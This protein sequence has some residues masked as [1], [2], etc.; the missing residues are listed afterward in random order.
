MRTLARTPERSSPVQRGR[1]SVGAVARYSG[2]DVISS[3]SSSWISFA[4]ATTR[5]SQGCGSWWSVPF[6][7][8]SAVE[9]ERPISSMWSWMRRTNALASSGTAAPLPY[10]TTRYSARTVEPSGASH[11]NAVLSTADGTPRQTTVCSN[12]ARRSSCGIWAMCPNMS[13]R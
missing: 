9:E 3:S 5:P 2:S 12:P 7:N 6:M 13:G 8:S 11:Q 4:S 10:P 1:P